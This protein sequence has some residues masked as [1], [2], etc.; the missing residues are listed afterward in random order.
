MLRRIIPL[1][2]LLLLLAG[3]LRAQGAQAQPAT[4]DLTA[5]A[6][7]LLDAIVRGDFAAATQGFDARMKQALPAE[8]L[9]EFWT[10]LLGQAGVFQRQ[11]GTRTE[12]QGAYQVVF[13]TTEFE[14]ARVDMQAVFDAQGQVAG[15]FFV[16]AQP[17]PP[18]GGDAGPPYAKKDAFQ[19][20]EVTV[21]SGEWALPGTL[22]LPVGAGP[23]P[24]VVLV[25]GS[26]PHDRDETLGPNKPFRDL[27]WGLASRGVAV[28]RYEKRTKAHAGSLAKISRPTVREEVI[29]DAVA[30][31]AL[32]RKTALID[33][34]RVHVLGH[35]LGGTLIPRIGQADPQ[36]AGLIVLAGTA[37]P[38][39]DVMVEQVSYIASLDG[40][41]SETEKTQIE[42][43]RKQAGQIGELKEDSAGAPFG[44][45]ASYWLDL[46]GYSAPEAA[47]ALQQPLLVLQGERDYQVTMTDF[48]AWKKA[49]ADRKDVTFKSYPKLNHLF[50]EGE[51]KS[52]PAEYQKAGHV[53][54]VVIEDVASWIAGLD[55]AARPPA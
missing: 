35:S 15:L 14:K 3:N 11:A 18:P 1:C 13:V 2:C 40:T 23:F 49:L 47:K 24:A 45:P 39:E 12:T 33:P 32:L 27:A 51:G 9:K 28:L 4:G 31:V 48:A 43:F 19:E 26:G 42:E 7:A 8:K 34:K 41:V 53:A 37:R 54:P 21:G 55:N 5:K 38:L 6:T 30:A 22:T 25:H 44:V 29:D 36:I 50:M 52:A 16:P 10:A 20:K 46:R 17:A